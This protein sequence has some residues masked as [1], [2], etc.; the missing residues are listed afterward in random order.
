MGRINTLLLLL[1]IL[2]TSI[3]SLRGQ[4]SLRGKVIDTS[5]LEISQV[6]LLLFQNEKIISY[7][8]SDLKGDFTLKIPSSGKYILKAT[9]LGYSAYEKE[10]NI[11]ATETLSIEISLISET[12]SL[13]EVVLNVEKN[14]EV[15]N[16]TL[17]FKAD[18]FKRKSQIVLEDL[19]KNIPGIQVGDSGNI[20]FQG[21]AI[22]KIKIDNDDLFGQG[23][24]ILSKNLNSEVVDKIEILQNY[25]D[26]KILKQ[27]QKNDEVAINLTLKDD[28]KSS[29]FGN[30]D[31][32]ATFNGRYKIKSNTI[33]L[34]NKNKAYLFQDFNNIGDEIADNIDGILS[35]SSNNRL[36]N[37]GTNANATFFIDVDRVRPTF[38][39]RISNRNNAQFLSLADIYTFSKDLKLTVNGVLTYDKKRYNQEEFT[40]FLVENPF[41][42]DES[43]DIQQKDNLAAGKIALDFKR[44]NDEIHFDAL[45]YTGDQRINNN[46]IQNEIDIREHLKNNASVFQLQGNYTR[47]IDS[48]KAIVLTSK[49]KKDSKPQGYNISPN[50]YGDFVTDNETVLGIGARS[51]EVSEFAGVQA[52]F[53]TNTKKS[54][55]EFILGID[56]QNQHLTS[57]INSVNT[58]D[59]EQ[60]SDAIFNNNFKLENQQTYGG[61]RANYDLDKVD[62]QFS[63][64]ASLKKTTQNDNVTSNSEHFFQVNPFLKIDLTPIKNHKFETVLAINQNTASLGNLYTGYILRNYRAFIQGNAKNDIINTFQSSLKYTYGNWTDRFT[65]SAIADYSST[66]NFYSVDALLSP[67]FNTVTAVSGQKSEQFKAEVHT[68]YFLKFM[69]TNLKLNGQFLTNNY[70]DIINNQERNVISHQLG[71]GFSLRS[72]YN[73]IFNYNLGVNWIKTAFDIG[74][75]NNRVTNNK[76]F[77]DIDLNINDKFNMYFKN[78]KYFFGN[79]PRDSNFYFSSIEAD[80]DIIPKTL[81]AHGRIHN[82][83]DN[84]SFNISSLTG[85]STFTSQT[86]LIGRYV[87]LGLDYRF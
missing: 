82:L 34:L 81:R 84:D 22:S 8:S 78:E 28:R 67:Q 63:I 54:N 71:Y 24:K 12:T 46:L 3:T 47:S 39:D 9:S 30:V 61:L 32:G 77:L 38:D 52:A 18:A 20:T 10:L 23:Y 51:K 56:S 49:Y 36:Y 83:F 72:D 33:S 64:D 1:F 85:V 17:I 55:Y 79:L 66:K 45:Y 62:I 42:L 68:D 27:V 70:N 6:N 31:A 16:D 35:P 26:S 19:L 2:C 41:T 80:Y 57:D 44:N 5:G 43:Y 53:V 25:N 14:I 65:A 86:Q 73:S 4:T 69:K 40:T 37:F 21:K 58:T 48:N 7:T 59:E 13:D 15:R 29:L 11:T 60:A 76:M 87:M 75:F 50:I 74:T